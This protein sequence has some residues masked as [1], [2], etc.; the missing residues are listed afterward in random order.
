[1][2]AKA[3]KTGGSSTVVLGVVLMFVPVM[4]L[5]AVIAIS[6][7]ELMQNPA[8]QAIRLTARTVHATRP[9]PRK[10]AIA[11]VAAVML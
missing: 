8:N 10:T 7:M 11:F 5:L 3:V 6:N 4:I 1:M 9:I 2:A